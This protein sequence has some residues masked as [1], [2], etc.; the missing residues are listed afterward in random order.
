MRGR[1]RRKG[2]RGKG[3]GGEG[4]EGEGEGKEGKGKGRGG[5]CLPT[6][7]NVPTPMLS[8]I[9]VLVVN[10]DLLCRIC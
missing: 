5:P 8:A 6:I 9:N 2:R 7:K 1:K 4:K 10:S 3:R